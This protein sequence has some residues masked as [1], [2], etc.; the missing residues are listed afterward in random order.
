MNVLTRRLKNMSPPQVLV[1]GFLVII[2]IGSVLLWL[3]FSHEPGVTVSYVNALF[4]ATSAVCVTGLVVVD[5]G[6]TFSF[7]GEVILIFLI[8][9][10]G[11]GF[12]T[13]STLIAIML[14][15]RISHR[16][17]LLLQEALNQ[18]STQGIVRLISRVIW[19]M[20]AIE[21][22]G[23]LLLTAAWSAEMGPKQALYYGWFHSV[24]LFNNAGF[25]LFGQFN[26]MPFS[27]MTHYVDNHFV[28]LVSMALVILGGI[29]FF[30]LTDLYDWR[31]R[32]RLSVHSKVVLATT[33]WLLL[34]GALLLLFF[35]FTNTR[36]LASLQF[37][38]KLT[39]S[40]FQSTASRTAGVNTL[41]IA[42][43]RESTQF[44][45]II[46][47]FIGAAPGSTGG[48]VKVTSFAIV[49]AAVFAALRGRDEVVLFQ[50]RI[51]RER[52]YKALT[53]IIISLSLVMFV[54]MILS[55]T[56]KRP[57][58]DNL[59]EATSAFAT[60]GLSMGLTPELT[61]F[62]KFLIMVTM[63]IGRLGPL[64]MAY[65]LTFDNKRDKIGYPE[66]KIII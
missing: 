1:L 9:L 52:V 53:I 39:A 30:V 16:D 37:F 28:S 65:S 10:G 64:T 29:G 58:L 8:Q 27:G 57:F 51:L 34:V 38:E 44:L 35:E 36:T 25:D 17:R 61:L 40:F 32:R 2:F 3:P 41:D 66:G 48:G 63:F 20:L 18:D 12:M 46:L 47:M 5:T 23:M 43:L 14:K 42:A 6:T 45:L 56:E 19:F 13:F 21:A 11:M 59:F 55:Y 7:P 49:T 24:S 26:N 15:R 54:A 22:A 50:Y 31:E 62:G 4:T 33:G 60:V